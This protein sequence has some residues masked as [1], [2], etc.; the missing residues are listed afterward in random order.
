MLMVTSHVLIIGS[1][2]QNE[3]VWYFLKIRVT[4]TS[5]NE[6]NFNGE[7]RHGNI[8][9]IRNYGKFHFDPDRMIISLLGMHWSI[10]LIELRDTFF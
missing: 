8:L 2:K 6:R 1:S 4:S 5:M 7:F 9:F 3:T 10:E